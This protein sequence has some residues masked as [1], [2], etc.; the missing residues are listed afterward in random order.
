MFNPTNVLVGQNGG[1]P[2][3]RIATLLLGAGL[4]AASIGPA[5]AA[6]PNYGPSAHPTRLNHA[7]MDRANGRY[8]SALNDL[9]AHGY[10]GISNFSAEG[11]DFT[12]TAWHNGKLV[13]VMLDP[14]TGAITPRG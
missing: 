12:A 5:L 4:I 11:Q 6:T 9:E 14:A 2:M 1:F 10:T 3:T 13:S 8:T 7:T